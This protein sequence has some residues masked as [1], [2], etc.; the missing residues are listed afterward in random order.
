MVCDVCVLLATPAICNN[1]NVTT[2]HVASIHMRGRHAVATK[3]VK[4]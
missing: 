2:I 4:A 3:Q 1:N